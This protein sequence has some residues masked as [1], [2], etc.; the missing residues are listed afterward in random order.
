[1]YNVA[2]VSMCLMIW[3]V[4]GWVVKNLLEPHDV[5]TNIVYRLTLERF[6]IF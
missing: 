5:R 1:M 3:H 2:S 6:Y 4:K